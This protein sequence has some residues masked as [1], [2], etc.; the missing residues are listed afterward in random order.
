[1]LDWPAVR[2]QTLA[3]T[4]AAT[5]APIGG[6]RGPLSGLGSSAGASPSRRSRSPRSPVHLVRL[7]APCEARGRGWRSALHPADHLL[8]L[9]CRPWLVWVRRSASRDHPYHRSGAA[10]GSARCAPLRSFGVASIDME[11][12]AVATC[13]AARERASFDAELVQ[14]TGPSESTHG[15][16]STPDTVKFA[17]IVRRDGEYPS[18]SG[19]A[20]MP[21]FAIWVVS[22]AWADE[23]RA[24]YVRV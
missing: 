4:S 20:G 17:T 22:V 1:M 11:P 10:A 21:M 24:F 13:W 15:L 18:T 19:L 8:P 7:H 23:R 5:I 12:S 6:R 9:H 3:S 14:A 16:R 2:T